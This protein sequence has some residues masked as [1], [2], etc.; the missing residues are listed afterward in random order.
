[1]HFRMSRSATALAALLAGAALSACGGGG[2]GA[3]MGSS[4]VP[5]TASPGGIWRG[6]DPYT[7]DPLLGIVTETGQ[8]TFIRTTDGAQY[9]GGLSA[10]GT[11][12]SGSF[13]GVLPV[14]ETFQDGSTFGSGTISGTFAAQQS[15]SAGISFTTAGNTN[16]GSNPLSLTFDSLYDVGSSL[17]AIA[18][19]YVDSASVSVVNVNANGAIFIQDGATGCAVNG[20]AGL[21]DPAYD[22]YQV[23]LAF[24]NCTGSFAAL[25]GSTATG[26]AV[27]DTTATPNVLYVGVQNLAAHFVLSAAYQRQ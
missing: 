14:G 10:A 26:L 11:A 23:D 3:G 8:F 13:T 27:L 21:I 6:T 18:G 12:L 15:I 24:A 17:A 22:A 19:S 5:T 1:M 25:N 20:L 4:P 16:L 7:G 2:L 9:V